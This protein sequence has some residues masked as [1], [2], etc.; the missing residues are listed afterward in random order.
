MAG[1][2]GRRREL[3][4]EG[5]GPGL[6]LVINGTLIGVGGVFLATASVA[7][8]GIAAAAAVAMAAVVTL[9]GGYSQV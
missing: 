3:P 2:A 1:R 6:V 4:Q 8:T 7:V 5:G 9:A